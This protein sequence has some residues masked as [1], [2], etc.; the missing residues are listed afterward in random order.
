MSEI[1]TDE[2]L[3]IFQIPYD[4]TLDQLKGAYRKTSLAVHPDRGGSAAMF[5]T[6]NQCYQHLLHELSFR[7]G[8]ASHFDLKRDYEQHAE[9]HPGLSDPSN[10]AAPDRQFS[11]TR[12]NEVYETH[13]VRDEFS[14]GG[15]GDFLAEGV[16]DAA[17]GALAENQ[18]FESAFAA[19][20]PAQAPMAMIVKPAPLLDR[21][22]LTFTEIGLEEVDDYGAQVGD[23][24]A[25]DCKQ[26]YSEDSMAREFHSFRDAAPPKRTVEELHSQRQAYFDEVWDEDAQIR[27][28]IETRAKEDEGARRRREIMLRADRQNYQAHAQCN[29]QMLGFR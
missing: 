6:V 20:A 12:F 28:E 4:F 23:I 15:Y 17:P 8:T 22:S 7:S 24:Q 18:S 26:A 16:R 29:R 2:A 9:M 27:Y 5:D 10:Y 3:A 14:R 21:G 13:C 19:R 25:F 11:L 1:S